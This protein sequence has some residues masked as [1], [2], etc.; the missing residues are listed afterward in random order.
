MKRFKQ[1]KTAVTIPRKE[2][3]EIKWQIAKETTEKASL[4][5]L[6]AAIDELGLTEDQ[7]CNIAERVSRYATYID[8]H[9]VELEDLRKSSEKNTGVKL[10]GWAT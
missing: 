7:F 3:V 5:V 8:D 6:L 2:L 1:P 9:I 10:K 4:L